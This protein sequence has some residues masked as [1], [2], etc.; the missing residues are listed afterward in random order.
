[1]TVK[2]GF[3]HYVNVVKIEDYQ[4]KSIAINLV[5]NNGEEREIPVTENDEIVFV[6][7]G[8]NGLH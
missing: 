5:F 7:E 4:S 1:M 2:I 3:I 8:E 6:M